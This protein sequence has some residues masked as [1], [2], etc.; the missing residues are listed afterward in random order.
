[1]RNTL[2]FV[3]SRIFLNTTKVLGTLSLMCVTFCQH[4]SKARDCDNRSNA[5]SHTDQ[6]RGDTKPGIFTA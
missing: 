5:K 4:L 6:G 3:S 2:K 1:M